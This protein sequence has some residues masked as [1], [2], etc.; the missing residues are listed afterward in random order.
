[1]SELEELKIRLEHLRNWHVGGGSAFTQVGEKALASIE[2]NLKI[3]E[4]LLRAGK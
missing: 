1:M 2:L 3:A 4:L